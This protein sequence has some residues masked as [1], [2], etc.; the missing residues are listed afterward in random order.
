MPA[1]LPQEIRLKVIQLHIQCYS[2]ES[3]AS[4]LNIAPQSVRNIIEE[5][6]RGDYPEYETFLDHL[7][8]LRTLSRILRSKKRTLQ[9]A[10]IG[11]TVFNALNEI[12][13]EPVDLKEQLQLFQ[14]ITAPE[15]PAGKFARAALRLT[16]LES[17]T[18]MSFEALEQR[19]PKLASTI[20]DLEAKRKVLQNEIVSL[21][22][23]K[24]KANK[25]YE[26]T[27]TEN[28]TRLEGEALNTESKIRQLKQDKE[29]QLADN[30]TTGEQIGRYGSVRARLAAKGFDIEKLGVLEGIIDAFVKHGWDAPKTI[31]YLKQVSNLE[32]QTQAI[33]DQC[34]IVQKELVAKNDELRTIEAKVVQ[35]KGGLEK[36][37]VLEDESQERLAESENR[38]SENN[39][40]LDFADTFLALFNDVSKV[41]DEQ[42]LQISDK[43][44]LVVETRKKLP[45]L[46]VDY[47]ALKDRLLLLVETVL[48][49]RLTTRETLEELTRKHADLVLDVQFD[50][51]GKLE[52]LRRKQ[53]EERLQLLI[54]RATFAKEKE[55]FANASTGQLLALA[56]SRTK[57]GEFQVF[58][59]KTC[60]FRTAYALGSRSHRPPEYCPSCYITLTRVSQVE[61]EV[62]RRLLDPAS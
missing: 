11:I 38:M 32:Q 60:R 37:R 25:D 58:F 30:R 7:D 12:G 23:A 43:L 56:A 13:I 44:Q 5:L 62:A 48:G 16:K 46:P 40:R 51:L 9:Q 3:I 4:G 10:L 18:G 45:G 26:T 29:K 17:T 20:S 53:A 28:K 59:C 31:N 14:R 27:M 55:A 42:L 39:L 34:A 19:I 24:V 61:I 15:F 6:K 1:R 49:K 57:S 2:S 35:E 36:L 41:R 52:V 54:E 47:Q 22:S 8:D 21:E 33:K 50:R